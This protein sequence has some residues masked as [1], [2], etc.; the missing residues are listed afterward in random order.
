MSVQLVL[1][2]RNNPVFKI[3]S[4]AYNRIASIWF[5]N[6][7][8]SFMRYWIFNRVFELC[9]KLCTYRKLV[10]YLVRRHMGLI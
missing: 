7:N 2:H 3:I 6:L 10:A 4:N 1:K 9:Y 5:H 8:K